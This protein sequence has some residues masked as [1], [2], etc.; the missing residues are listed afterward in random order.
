MVALSAFIPEHQPPKFKA[1]H[2]FMIRLKSQR[3]VV[4]TGSVAD[5]PA[6]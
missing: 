3:L 5:P 2:P 6:A 4:F 1:D